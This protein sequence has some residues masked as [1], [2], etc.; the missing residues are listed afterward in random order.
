[1]IS[2]SVEYSNTNGYLERKQGGRYEGNIIVD[3]VDLSPIEGVYFKE[4][5]KQYLWLKRKPL[6]EY[7]EKEEKYLQR[8]REPR[9]E[10]YLEKQNNGVVAYV[11]YFIFLRLK[12]K[13]VGIW[14]IVLGKNK[15]RLNF[16]IERCPQNEQI[17]INKTSARKNEF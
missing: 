14:D 6:L 10:A 7:S 11:G 2:P 8:P 5:N 16:Y 1:M 15:Q 3:K 17:I 13:I 12:Y 9:W 4:D